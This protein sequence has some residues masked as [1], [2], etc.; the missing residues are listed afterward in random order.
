MSASSTVVRRTEISSSS[1]A[2]H[3]SLRMM[4]DR[5][6]FVLYP[7]LPLK[8]DEDRHVVLPTSQRDHL[9]F[10]LH[11]AAVQLD[12]QFIELGV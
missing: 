5:D 12:R 7:L 11:R 1:T 6:V 9:V 4:A 3:L 8:I 2:I 10:R